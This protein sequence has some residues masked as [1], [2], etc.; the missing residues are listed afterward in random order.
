MLGG[1]SLGDPETYGLDAMFPALFLALLA[2]QLRSRSAVH[3]AVLGG[4]I[5]LLLIPIAP[6]GVPVMAA[7]TGALIAV[8]WSRS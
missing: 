6:A 5:A 4:G 7:V 8:R 2:G 3:A 1:G